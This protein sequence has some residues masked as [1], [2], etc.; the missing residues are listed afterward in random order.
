MGNGPKAVSEFKNGIGH[1]VELENRYGSLAHREFESLPLRHIFLAFRRLCTAAIANHARQGPGASGT[2][3]WVGVGRVSRFRAVNRVGA[4]GWVGLHGHSAATVEVTLLPPKQM[5]PIIGDRSQFKYVVNLP[6]SGGVEICH[7][8][9]R[10][11]DT[12]DGAVPVGCR[13]DVKRLGRSVLGEV[14]RYMEVGAPV[15]DRVS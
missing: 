7:R 13:A 2:G 3:T 10:S 5:C 6:R 14:A 15:T 11:L 4:V 1:R 12:E 9:C 8:R